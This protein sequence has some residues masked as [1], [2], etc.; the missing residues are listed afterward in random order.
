MGLTTMLSASP[1]KILRLLALVGLVLTISEG[2]ALASGHFSRQTV[3]VV[4]QQQ[5]TLQTVQFAPATQFQFAPVSTQTLQLAPATT[6]LQLAPAMT[7]TFQMSP[8]TQ[9]QLAPAATQTYQLAPAST[10]LQLAPAM[11]QSLQLAP[12]TQLQLAPAAAQTLQFAPAS[13]QLQFAPAAIQT[14][15]VVG[16]S[17]G[18]FQSP[19]VQAS[20]DDQDYMLLAQGF[21]GKISSIRSLEDFVKGQADKLFQRGGLGKEEIATLLLDQV[22]GFM[23]ANGFGIP[24]QLIEPVLK[25]V[26][27]RVIVNRGTA[28]GGSG[29]TTSTSQPPGKPGTSDKTG[30]A[31]EISGRVYITPASGSSGS[32]G[33]TVTTPAS[34][35]GTT[36][37]S[38]V[39]GGTSTTSS[40]INTGRT[41]PNQNANGFTIPSQDQNALR[42]P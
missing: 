33:M 14:Y 6:N 5:A 41:P 15:Q 7:Q 32:G 22:K 11:T 19:G 25:R 20:P 21:G 34:V 17:V 10:Q 18:T 31:F 4:P 38:S 30:G 8:T 35:S 24:F 28:S 12:T 39:I 36:P 3:Y 29:G 2:P 1:P 37:P 23:T 26:I 40:V 9:L 13:T 27:D 42:Q 16:A